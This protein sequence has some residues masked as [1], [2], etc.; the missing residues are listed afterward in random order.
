M[1]L[2]L[3]EGKHLAVSISADF[4][5]HCVWMGT[6]GLTSPGYLARGVSSARRSVCPA[7]CRLFAPPTG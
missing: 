7:C 3:P 5:A 6:F 2:D 4:D 1:P